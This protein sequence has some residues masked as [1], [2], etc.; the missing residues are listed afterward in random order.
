MTLRMKASAKYISN[1]FSEIPTPV[2]SASKLWPKCF[3]MKLE[4][5]EG[6][7]YM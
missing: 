5:D 3:T 6:Q 4:R 7:F 1:I 2:L